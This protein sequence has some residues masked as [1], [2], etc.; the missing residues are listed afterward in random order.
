MIDYSIRR[1]HGQ[2]CNYE[3]KSMKYKFLITD[4]VSQMGTDPAHAIYRADMYAGAEKHQL[5][6]NK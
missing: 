6:I 3:T 1:I 4:F 2:G 5:K